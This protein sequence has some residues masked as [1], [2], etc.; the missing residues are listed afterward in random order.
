MAKALGWSDEL[1]A[2]LRQRGNGYSARKAAPRDLPS[3]R[4]IINFDRSASS[5]LAMARRCGGHQRLQTT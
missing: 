5:H 1:V 3:D 2:E 4:S